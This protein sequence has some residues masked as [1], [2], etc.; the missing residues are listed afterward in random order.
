MR[1]IPVVG[2]VAGMGRMAVAQERP[3]GMTR[4]PEAKVAYLLNC[5]GCHGEAGRSSP[6]LVPDLKSQ[7]G[8]FLCT[9]EGR[10]YLVRL[11]NVAF[12][13]LSSSSLTVLM[14]FMVFDMG[15][16]SAPAGAKPYTVAEVDRLRREPLQMGNF[17]AYRQKTVAGVV[18]ACPAAAKVSSFAADDP[19]VLANRR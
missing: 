16:G 3:S 2:L 10:N 15:E 19:Y 8:Y 1:L 7:V 11:P 4:L 5:G 6:A 13:H 17:M 14:N 12:S 18:R 9:P